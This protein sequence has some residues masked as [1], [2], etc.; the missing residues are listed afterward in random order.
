M[1]KTVLIIFLLFSFLRTANGQDVILGDMD[2]D[3][4][5]SI[6]DVTE[7]INVLIGKSEISK[8]YSIE[9]FIRDNKLSGT[10]LYNGELRTYKDGELVNKNNGHEYVDLGLSVLWASYNVG[11]KLPE[12][13]GDYF[14]WGETMPKNNYDWITYKWIEKDGGDWNN[15]YKYTI[16]DN[17]SSV[18]WIIDGKFIGDGKY[19]LDMEDDAARANWGGDWRMP[20]NIELNELKEK[21][22]WNWTNIYGVN[23]YKI[24]GQNGNFIFLPETGYILGDKHNNAGEGNYWT[25]SIDEHFSDCAIDLVFNSKKIGT[26]GLYD[27]RRSGLCV[28]PVCPIDTIISI[29]LA[30]NTYLILDD[31]YN[32]YI[33]YSIYPT[34]VKNKTLVW[35]SSNTSVAIVSKDGKITAFNDGTCNITVAALDGS[36]K[37]TCKVIVDR[38]KYVDLGLSVKW[39]TCN[40]GANNPS[41]FGDYFAWG[42]NKSKSYFDWDNYKFGKSNSMSKYC[43]DPEWG[44]VDD[45]LGLELEDDAAHFNWGEAWR[46][47]TNDEWGELIDNCYCEWTDDYNG[48][49]VLGYIIYKAKNDNDKGKEKNRMVTPSL[50][51]SYTII[52]T[53]IFLPAAGNSVANLPDYNLGVYGVYG[54]YVS[55]SLDTNLPLQSVNLS[56]SHYGIANDDVASKCYGRTIRP[57]CK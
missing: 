53:H 32:K 6:L 4:K 18:D 10:F 49:K 24:T 51:S 15:I 11:A 1:K 21:C 46:I 57:V 38:H 20:T 9:D 5:I 52:D 7:L 31:N 25:N 47:P 41:E 55:S 39:A 29:S 44:V 56:F 2:Y 14:A 48:L 3:G 16:P 12:K 19:I 36:A 13:I 37:A 50:S 30:D 23:G 27:R 28:R 45:K 33:H 35:Y 22:S 26:P 40:I 8:N 42:E 34:D 43:N 54:N 17:Q